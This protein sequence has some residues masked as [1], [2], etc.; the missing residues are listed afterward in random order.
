MLS[1]KFNSVRNSNLLLFFAAFTMA[2]AINSW[3]TALPFIIVRLGGNESDVGKCFALYLGIYGLGCIVT[4]SILSHLNP[5]RTVLSGVSFM[6]VLAC[7]MSAMILFGTRQNYI[8]PVIVL[9]LLM[10]LTGMFMSFFW[11]FLMGWLSAA[12]EGKDLNRR[13]GLFNA[14]WSSGSLI[15]PFII[16]FLVERSSLLPM[17]AA[18]I[19]IAACGFF[20]SLTPYRDTTLDSGHTLNN[21][22]PGLDF[23]DSKMKSLRWISR[24]TLLT[25]CACNVLVRTQL[26]LLFKF[27]LGLTESDF[28]MVMT[29]TMLVNCLTFIAAGKWHFWHH[30]LSVLIASQLFVALHLVLILMANDLWLFYVAMMFSGCGGAI[31]Y[32][33]HLFYGMS[34]SRKRSRRMAIHEG[35]IAA[36]VVIGSLSG[37]Y[38]SNY[39]GPY[40]P[41][42]F[43]LLI[44]ASGLLVQMV[45]W[46]TLRRNKNN[47]QP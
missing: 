43:G 32:S 31:A 36:G 11:P 38:L 23:N 27:N 35:T 6:F 28:G 19:S 25:T 33:S 16:G 24:I 14:S 20:V 37:G 7:A 47:P 21:E 44:I 34:G 5:K 46:H 30:K 29:V 2:F 26:G 17:I 3:W 15:S 8:K 42:K 10:G 1:G 45:V 41:Y 9:L 13:L 12:H 39:L 18:A 22:T 4:G 40:Q